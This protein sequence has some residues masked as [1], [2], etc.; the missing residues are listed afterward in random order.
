MPADDLHKITK[1]CVREFKS[2]NEYRPPPEC[3]IHPV[4]LPGVVSVFMYCACTTAS[5]NGVAGTRSMCATEAGVTSPFSIRAQYSDSSSKYS[6]FCSH[7]LKQNQ[8]H[9]V[10]PPEFLQ[11]I[12]QSSTENGGVRL[13]YLRKDK[14]IG[15]LF[16]NGFFWEFWMHSV[17]RDLYVPGTDM[18]D[19]GA[20]IGTQT[21]CMADVLI[22]HEAHGT[23]HAFEPVYYNLVLLNTLGYKE[24]HA[25]L[26]CV[27]PFGVNDSS[28]VLR[29]SIHPW[30][31]ECDLNFGAT[32]LDPALCDPSKLSLYSGT[33]GPVDIPLVALDNARFVSQNITRRVSVVKIDVEGMELKVLKGMRRIIEEDRPCIIVEIWEQRFQTFVK[34]E[35]GA[36]LMESYAV[37]KPNPDVF[38]QCRICNED[39]IFVPKERLHEIETSNKFIPVDVAS[40]ETQA[41]QEERS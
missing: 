23:V 14:A 29:T 24:R 22:E 18:I 20:H 16:E 31:S 38:E 11:E 9:F 10:P 21:M 7:R 36:T 8:M 30:N 12:V 35:E 33:Y 6:I 41:P 17:I 28:G 26:V 32:A 19:A 1:P 39:Y 13:W 40:T 25:E 34:S 15:R 2:A 4:W 3:E 37:F 5:R 27:Y